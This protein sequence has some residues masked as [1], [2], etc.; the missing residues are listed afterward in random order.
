MLGDVRKA[1][2]WQYGSREG[3]G[4]RKNKARSLSLLLLLLVLSCF[5]LRC[6]ALNCVAFALLCTAPKDG[7]TPLPWEKKR[8]RR[9]IDSVANNFSNHALELDH[10]SKQKELNQIP[11]LGQKVDDKLR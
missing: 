8:R 9:N 5:A 6:V 3:P 2:S 11:E 10:S 7:K 1:K 4:W